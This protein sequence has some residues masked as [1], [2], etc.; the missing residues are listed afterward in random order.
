MIYICHQTEELI[1]SIADDYY[2][3][4]TLVYSI[5]SNFADMFEMEIET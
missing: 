4:N 5:H 2:K 3:F 1:V